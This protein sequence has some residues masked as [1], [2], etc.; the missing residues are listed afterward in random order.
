[1]SASLVYWPVNPQEPVGVEV[2]AFL[3]RT[4]LQ[5]L[6]GTYPIVLDQSSIPKLMVIKELYEG[7]ENPW[8]R[9]IELVEAHHPH[10]IRIWEEY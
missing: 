1:M 6:F 3:V 4:S 2:P 7:D 5:K 10:G 8:A 9:I